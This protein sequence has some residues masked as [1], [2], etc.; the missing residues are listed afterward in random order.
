MAKTSLAVLESALR[1]RKLD[2]TLSTA[3]APVTA[4]CTPTTVTA[5]DTC[6]NGGLPRGQ[7]CEIAGAAGSG[8]T[9]LLLQLLAGVTR[10][11]EIAA[12]VDTS[13]RLDV[14]SACA[15]GIDLARLLWVR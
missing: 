9:T 7:L 5:I 10:Q 4:G 14:A 13:D 1:E 6:L 15:A 8:R 11:G 3:A 12:L 2:R